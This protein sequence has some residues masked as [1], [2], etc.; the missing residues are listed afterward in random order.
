MLMNNLASLIVSQSS[1]NS[2]HIESARQWALRGLQT[3]EEARADI[4][5]KEEKP[6][7]DC[8]HVFAA[9]L[10]NLGMLHEVSGVSPSSQ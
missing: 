10:F 9:I 2:T 7:D 5:R 1:V 4:E 8:E 3:S 6:V